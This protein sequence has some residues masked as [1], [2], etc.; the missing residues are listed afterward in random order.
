M[1]V[2]LDDLWFEFCELLVYVHSP[3]MYLLH[4][5]YEKVSQY[6]IDTLSPSWCIF[7]SPGRTPEAI[8]TNQTV[9]LCRISAKSVEQFLRQCISSR[10]PLIT[11]REI[12]ILLWGRWLLIVLQIWCLLC[13]FAM[14]LVYLWYATEA[15]S[16]M[17]NHCVRSMSGLTLD[18][19]AVFAELDHIHLHLSALRM[20]FMSCI[21]GST[22]NRPSKLNGDLM[23]I[24]TALQYNTRLHLS[25]SSW[26]YNWYCL[27]KCWRGIV[28]K[29]LLHVCSEY[30]HDMI[31]HIQA[32][33]QHFQL[34]SRC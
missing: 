16:S 34:T 2:C 25:S 26:R 28:Q 6:Q 20:S 12:T 24:A 21:A 11:M 30:K 10:H 3:L 32:S 4:D 15:R 13:S 33:W 29:V 23:F 18:I 22:C 9:T 14:F 31:V 27:K 1:S 19:R 5:V 7:G 8:A 17:A